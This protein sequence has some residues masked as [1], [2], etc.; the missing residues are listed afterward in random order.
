M[1]GKIFIAYHKPFD[2]IKGDFIV[3]VHAGRACTK[4]KEIGFN[5]NHLHTILDD[6]IGD[7]TGN[8]ISDRNNEFSECTVLYWAWKNNKF[9]KLRYVGFFQYRRQLILNDFFEK[10]KNDFEKKVYK[11]VHFK[12]IDDNFSSRIGLTEENIIHALDTYDCL[13]PYSSDLAAMNIS[14][15]YEDWVRKIP[16]VHL[17]DLV[18][19]EK[20]MAEVH[21][22]LQE[23]FEEYINSP[24]KL[25]YQLF[26]TRPEIAKRYC[27][28]MFNILFRIDKR[29]NTDMYSINGK[30]TL[31]YL[32]E[33]LYGFYFT[34]L[35]D[36][37][38]IKECGVTFIEE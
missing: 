35:K 24:Q 34:R 36:E 25:M 4:N 21:P 11:C 12:R 19:L 18:E 3:P 17:G 23:S 15:P 10:S 29:I 28:W 38:N 30:R 7:D 6:M 32:A 31:G 33:I 14:S 2:I 22:E 16:G 8:N 37:Y 26:I 20:L 5:T 1:E 9:D 27:D 13:I